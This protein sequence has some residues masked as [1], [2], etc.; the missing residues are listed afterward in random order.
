MKIAITQQCVDDAVPCDPGQCVI[1]QAVRNALGESKS[2]LV[3]AKPGKTRIVLPNR[4]TVVFSTPANLGKFIPAFDAGSGTFPLGEFLLGVV[5]KSNRPRAMKRR[6][7][8]HRARVARGEANLGLSG[9][10]IGRNSR[11]LVLS[12]RE[13]AA[14]KNSD[15]L[16]RL[17]TA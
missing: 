9:T 2:I 6:S 5:P 15:R 17:M 7:A 1:A 4:D 16:R 14:N 10:R 3:S 11:V 13:K 8:A 12:A